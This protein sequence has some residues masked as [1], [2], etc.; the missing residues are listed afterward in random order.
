VGGSPRPATGPAMRAGRATDVW[1]W[2]G[3]RP[4]SEL[5]SGEGGFSK[6]PPD[7]ARS[8]MPGGPPLRVFDL[9]KAGFFSR[10]SRAWAEASLFRPP[11]PSVPARGEL[12]AAS[13]SGPVSP[14]FPSA[15]S[16]RSRRAGGGAALSEA[17]IRLGGRPRPGTSPALTAAPPMN[18]NRIAL[19]GGSCGMPSPGRAP[20]GSHFLIGAFKHKKVANSDFC[21]RG[22]RPSS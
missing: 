10:R 1:R 21:P 2:A 5:R 18:G 12:Q 11:L 22:Q 9:R 3:P 6:E 15:D 4:F 20:R 7:R 14:R 17:H 13:K 19:T 16:R 8:K